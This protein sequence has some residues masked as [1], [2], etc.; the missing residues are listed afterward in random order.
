[1]RK[2]DIL[3]AGCVVLNLKDK[4]IGLIYRNKQK[5]FEF[6][7]G[8]LEYNENIEQCAIRETAEEIKRDLSGRK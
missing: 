3:K 2:K 6:P 1:M 7:K 8:H 5:D 4:K